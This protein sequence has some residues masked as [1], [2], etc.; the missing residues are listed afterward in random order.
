MS[1]KGTC[2]SCYS[3]PCVLAVLGSLP[4]GTRGGLRCISPPTPNIRISGLSPIGITFSSGQPGNTIIILCGRPGARSLRNLA[5]LRVA[6]NRPFKFW[7]CP[8]GKPKICLFF[9]APV[10]DEVPWCVCMCAY[11]RA[12][13]RV[14]V[15]VCV[16]VCVYVC[17]CVRVCA[18]KHAFNLLTSVS[19]TW[20]LASS[21]HAPIVIESLNIN[22]QVPCNLN[23][24]NSY[25]QSCAC[26]SSELFVPPLLGPGPIRHTQKCLLS[27]PVR[28]D[29]VR[30]AWAGLSAG[31]LPPATKH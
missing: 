27:T 26:R 28:S 30:G 16:R 23:C 17:V 2:P 22:F 14:C 9:M 6:R 24:G 8:P 5:F 29:D 31:Q 19:Q 3:T 13:M 15:C 18:C 1:T 10:R 25:T 12:C 4:L 7:L 11:V 20:R 21:E